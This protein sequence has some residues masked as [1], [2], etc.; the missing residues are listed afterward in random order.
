MLRGAVM[1][2][3]VLLFTMAFQSCPGPRN[4]SFR[5]RKLDEQS[6]VENNI[7]YVYK[8]LY[9]NNFFIA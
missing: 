8:P 3:C 2:S 6:F 7:E 1:G 4:R 5:I 9:A